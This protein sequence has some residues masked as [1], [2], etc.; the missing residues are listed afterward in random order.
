[1]KEKKFFT[2]QIID[3]F[4]EDPKKIVRFAKTLKYGKGPDG[5]WPGVRSPALHDVN[6]KFF[7]S[8]LTKLL[9]LSFDFNNHKVG[10][11]N[12][13]MYFQKT[14]P[15]DSKNKNNIVNKGLIHQD[16]NQPLVG[17]IYLTEGADPESGTSIM[18]P[19]KRYN[20]KEASK[21]RKKYTDK[22][23]YIYKKSIKDLTKKDLKDYAKLIKDANSNFA[24]NIKINNI[25]NRAVLYTG[26]DYHKVNSLYTGKK[27]RLTLVFFIKTIETTGYSPLQ[28]LNLVNIN[29]KYT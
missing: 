16:G 19:V 22:K 5:K 6:P 11:E 9:S 10:W 12:V 8:V 26:N 20:E 7:N 21:L 28:R 1:M 2:T 18:H 14:Y 25:F 4:F 27:E 29:L 13:Q 17:L 3:N 23:I 15:Y 24:E